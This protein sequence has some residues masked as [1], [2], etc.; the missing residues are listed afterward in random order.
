MPTTGLAIPRPVHVTSIEHIGKEVIVDPTDSPEELTAEQLNATYSLIYRDA[1]TLCDSLRAGVRAASI[2]V[3]A[4]EA[5]VSQSVVKAFVNQAT[6]P[7]A[8]TT[9]KLEAALARLG[10]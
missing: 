1:H 8:A 2:S 6:T 9:V 7:Q 4:R 5:K 3:V 10:A